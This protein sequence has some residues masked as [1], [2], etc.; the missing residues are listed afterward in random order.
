MYGNRHSPSRDIRYQFLCFRIFEV[1]LW[2]RIVWGPFNYKASALMNIIIIM[3]T[4][5]ETNIII[6]FNFRC[7]R[8]LTSLYESPNVQSFLNHIDPHVS[9]KHKAMYNPGC[10]RNVSWIFFFHMHVWSSLSFKC[11]FKYYNFSTTLFPLFMSVEEIVNFKLIKIDWNWFITI[12]IIC[13]CLMYFFHQI[14]FLN[15]YQVAYS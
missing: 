13:F 8:G 9:M 12:P 14:I 15:N 6:I 5:C 3:L 11:T 7:R 1:Y 2:W 4:R 10:L